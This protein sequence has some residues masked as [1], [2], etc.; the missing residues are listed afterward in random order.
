MHIISTEELKGILER[1]EPVVLIMAMSDAAFSMGHIPGSINATKAED[2]DWLEDL[3]APII[4]YCTGRDCAASWIASRLMI[5]AGY[6]NVRH[7]PG[8]LAAWSAAGLP[9][10]S[11]ARQ[12]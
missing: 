4:V 1:G 12:A 3:D 10:S 7:Y 6:R 11:S 9:L 2:L 5:T 8:G